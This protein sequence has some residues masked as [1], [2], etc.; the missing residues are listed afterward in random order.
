MADHG[1]AVE[2]EAATGVD[3]ADHLRTYRLFLSLTKWISIGVI[4]VLVLLTIFVL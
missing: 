2:F 3:Y 4:A 1:G